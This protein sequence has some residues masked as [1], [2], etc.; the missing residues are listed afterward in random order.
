MIGPF[1]TDIIFTG[2]AMIFRIISSWGS[3]FSWWIAK[4]WSIVPLDANIYLITGEGLLQ[5]YS[6][7]Q[8]PLPD[9]F[10][11]FALQLVSS[12]KPLSGHTSWVLPLPVFSAVVGRLAVKSSG[13]FGGSTGS[14]GV[15]G[16]RLLCI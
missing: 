3:S 12:V 6:G 9:H 13:F 11:S 7:L 2:Y 14:Q 1:G 5:G 16:Y 10:G 4:L 15:S 8:G